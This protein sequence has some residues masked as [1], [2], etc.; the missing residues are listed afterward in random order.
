MVN[1]SK[2]FWP[3]ALVTAW[4]ADF[5]FWG[6]AP[7]ISV[8]IWISV[9]LLVGFLLSWRAGARP[10]IGSLLLAVLIVFYAAVFAFRSDGPVSFFSALMVGG[11]LILLA[12]TFLSG[13]WTSYR[14]VDYINEGLKVVWGTISRPFL[15]FSTPSAEPT[16]EEKT[17]PKSN[18]RKIAPILRGV[19]IAVPVLAV[20]IALF[21]SADPVFNEGFRRLFNIEKLPEHLFR[22]VLILILG[23]GLVGAYLHAIL[24]SKRAEKPD[25]SKTW[26]KPFL[27]WTETG[28]LLGAVD[29]LFI[30]FVIL[31]IRYLFGG[32]ANINE[33]GFTYSQ[34]AVRGFN[35][36]VWVASLSLLLFLVLGTITKV[37]KK[38]QRIGFTALVVVLMANVLVILASSLTR[39]TLYESTYG[40]TV[41]RT[42]PHVFI[43][44]LGALVIAA[45]VLEL[46]QMR[47]RFGLALLVAVIGFTMTLTLINVDG[48]IVRKNVARAM[49]GEELDVR[50]LN[51]LSNDAV[52]AIV[53]YYNSPSIKGDLHQ[54]LG[55]ILACK[56]EILQ[57]T[58]QRPWQSYHF[59]RAAAERL[60]DENAASIGGIKLIA[61]GYSSYFV[62][63]G[64]SIYCSASFMD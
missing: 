59:S 46:L 37:E 6:K 50:Y 16:A 10:S 29:I 11:G 21:A 45:A 20:F 2:W 42:L 3:A 47:G 57:S 55:L 8:P 4:F 19:V 17:A 35:E 38:G 13:N 26:M 58:S 22:L 28:I 61:D 7:G 62:W 54:A 63:K 9:V 64:E 44:W 34:Y 53:E 49:I 43:Y 60:L 5:M 33:T 41:L 48:F 36:L 18:W 12:A 51:S 14:I 40:F 56:S 31:Q 25:P 32:S 27:G 52:P 15:S 30:V 24:P 23:F 1:Q 39:L